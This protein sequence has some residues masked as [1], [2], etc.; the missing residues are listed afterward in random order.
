MKAARV[1]KEGDL[2]GL[3]LG[4]VGDHD[5]GHGVFVVEARLSAELLLPAHVLSDSAARTHR[6]HLVTHAHATTAHAPPHTQATRD[7]THGW[8]C[9][10]PRA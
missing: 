7:T 4:G 8:W 1:E 3:G 2:D 6:L 10:L 9:G 5:A